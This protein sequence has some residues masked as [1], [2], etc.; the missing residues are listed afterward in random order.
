MVAKKRTSRSAKS[1]HLPLMFG[2]GLA[3]ILLGLGLAVGRFLHARES[4]ETAAAS[5]V[6]GNAPDFALVSLTGKT[7]RLSDLRGKPVVLNFWATWCPPCK[8]EMP[9]LER[10][11]ARLQGQVVFL[12]INF[13]EPKEMVEIFQ[14]NMGF[15]NLI[16]LVDEKGIAG[17]KYGVQALPTTFFVDAQGNIAAQ[18]MGILDEGNLSAYLDKLLK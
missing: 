6:Q 4:R 15:Q 14:E 7:Y 3:L 16:L 11:A 9:L 2:V 17:R 5:S 12:A 1:P 10:E 13:G 18:H 8:A